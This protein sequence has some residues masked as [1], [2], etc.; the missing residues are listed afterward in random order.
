[1]NLT[2][3][4]LLAV[5]LSQNI[6]A[7]EI[8]CPKG[9]RLKT[10]TTVLK[11]FIGGG[12]GNHFNVIV[13]QTFC[14]KL[15]ANG[16]GVGK[17]GLQYLVGKQIIVDENGAEIS[18]DQILSRRIMKF[19]P[20]G[21]QIYEAKLSMDEV[22]ADEFTSRNQARIV[23]VQFQNSTKEFWGFDDTESLVFVSSEGNGPGYLTQE[24]I[25]RFGGEEIALL[26]AMRKDR[27]SSDNCQLTPNGVV[28]NGM[29]I[30]KPTYS[31]YDLKDIILKLYRNKVCSFKPAKEHG[32][33]KAVDRKRVLELLSEVEDAR[34]NSSPQSK[35]QNDLATTQSTIDRLEANLAKLYHLRDLQIKR[36]NGADSTAVKGD[37]LVKILPQKADSTQ[38][39]EIK[40]RSDSSIVH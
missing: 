21:N 28:K 18:D 26:S 34:S 8:Q 30:Q 1:M 5:F 37:T 40:V 2:P 17:V 6:Y 38:A 19:D 7:F 35:L 14:E 4:I 36:L 20:Q 39:K 15:D 33:S 9:S 16:K 23:S 3:F 10:T 25:D 24:G 11:D 29:V 27:E 13:R 32:F 31:S 22:F 12:S